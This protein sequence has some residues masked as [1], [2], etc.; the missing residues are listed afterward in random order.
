MN[1]HTERGFA[2]ALEMLESAGPEFLQGLMW[3]AEREALSDE[4]REAFAAAAARR[5][6]EIDR[7]DA[8]RAARKAAE[9][10]E[11]RRTA[12]ARQAAFAGMWASH[13]VCVTAAEAEAK[14]KAAA[15]EREAAHAS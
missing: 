4:Q 6:V 11:R 3:D 12:P 8:E 15:A 13:W 10:A 2:N 9:A 5:R 7:E 14:T 1:M